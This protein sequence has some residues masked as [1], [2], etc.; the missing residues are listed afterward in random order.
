MTR[1]GLNRQRQND[2]A[3]FI[4]VLKRGK[5]CP[6]LVTRQK[7]YYNKQN[8]IEMYPINT[9]SKNTYDKK[10]AGGGGRGD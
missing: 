1:E 8:G 10:W 5:I 2:N 6:V 9:T 3:T 4:H 7:N